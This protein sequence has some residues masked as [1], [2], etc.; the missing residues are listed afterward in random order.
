M[1]KVDNSEITRFT[2]N[3]R[4]YSPPSLKTVQTP[5]RSLILDRIAQNFKNESDADGNKWDE[6]KAAT[7]KQRESKGVGAHPILQLRK[8]I[9]KGKSKRPQG[10][11]LLE[12]ILNAQ[13]SIE[14]NEINISINDSKINTY[15]AALDRKR[16]FFNIGK[17]TTNEILVVYQVAISKSL[18]NLFTK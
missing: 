6:L 12:S 7:I 17:A 16:P 11:S 14:D 15:A 1:L 4:S 3:L 8:L 2:T 13:I 9:S 10:Q 5:L 18:I